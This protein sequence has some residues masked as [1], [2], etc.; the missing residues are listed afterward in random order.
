MHF[1]QLK[2]R[3]FITLLGGAAATWPLAA[4]GQ[5]PAVPVIGFLFARSLPN[6]LPP[7]GFRQGLKEAGYGENVAIEVRGGDNQIDRLRELAADLVR[8][9]VSVIVTSGGAMPALAA[10]AA[11]ST[12]PIVFMMGP[13]PV[14]YGVVASLSRPGGNATGVSI[15]NHELAAKRLDLLRQ[16]IPQMTTVGYLAG[17]PGLSSEDQKSDIL[18]AAST[19]GLQVIVVEVRS[20]R[21][22]EAAFATLVDR[23]AGALIHNASPIIFSH[24]NAVSA[25]AA[26]HSIPAIYSNP[27]IV[28]GGGL[29]SYEA[30]FPVTRQAGAYVGRILMGEKPA[31]LP[32]LLPTK[33]QL[34]VN[35]KTAKA[36]GLTIPESFLLRADE[37]IE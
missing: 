7:P 10:K 34:V 14:K 26:R 23:R 15:L 6:I 12:I 3:E 29:M 27:W 9:Q 18:E 13:D 24:L 22:F 1:D 28:R 32:V 5:Q 33:F 19:L 30:D 8:H 11:T 31:D 17:V 21:D 35:L 20:E 25:L 2:R 36:L 16:L 37:V 4:R